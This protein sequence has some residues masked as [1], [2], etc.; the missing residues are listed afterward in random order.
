MLQFKKL[1]ESGVRETDSPATRRVIILSNYIAIT[2]A[3]PNI[4]LFVRIPG[5]HNMGGFLEMVLA[6]GIFSFPIVLNRWHLTLTSRL[7]ECW[8]PPILILWYMTSGMRDAEVVSVAAYD[9]LR[10]YL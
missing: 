1:I 8:L 9:G 3:L 4:F 6:I 7:Y 10:F 2:L 5:N